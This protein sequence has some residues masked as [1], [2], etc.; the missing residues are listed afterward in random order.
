MGNKSYSFPL[1]WIQEDTRVGYLTVDGLHRREYVNPVETL[2]V[3]EK[4]IVENLVIR[5]LSEVNHTGR[6]MET[7][8]NNGTVKRLC[9]PGWSA[10]RI[11]GSGRTEKTE[12]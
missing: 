5:D 12:F 8:V 6:P 7:F 4:A 11:T 3:G 2:H 9:A 1:V 10:D